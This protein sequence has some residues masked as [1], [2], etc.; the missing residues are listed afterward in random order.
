MM[1]Q[2]ATCTMSLVMANFCVS[3][4]LFASPW[5]H[6]SAETQRLMA[7]LQLLKKD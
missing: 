3:E 1:V 2:K 5:C 6:L 7:F 4:V